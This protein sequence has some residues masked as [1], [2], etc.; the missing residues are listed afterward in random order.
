MP[1][2][3]IMYLCLF[4]SAITLAPKTPVLYEDY[5]SLERSSYTIGELCMSGPISHTASY[6]DLVML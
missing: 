1:V 3:C 2:A 6:D 4:S 5:L